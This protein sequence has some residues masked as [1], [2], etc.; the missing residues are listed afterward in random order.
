M[1]DDGPDVT[2][3]LSRSGGSLEDNL[4]RWRGQVNQSRAEVKD[5][6]RIAG[7]DATLIDLEGRFSP[8]FGRDP[9][10]GWQMLGVIVPLP[11]NGYFMKLTGPVDQVEAVEQDFRSFVK[12][13]HPE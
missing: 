12:S 3:T 7:Y 10:D 9:Q 2:L 6:I 11:E 1:P 5:T 13:A 8:G 4:D